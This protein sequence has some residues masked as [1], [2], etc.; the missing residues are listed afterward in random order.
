MPAL[1]V[2]ISTIAHGA[3][4]LAIAAAIALTALH[5]RTNS[6]SSAQDARVA[7]VDADSLTSKLAHCQAIGMAAQNDASCETVWAENRRRFFT[8]RPSDYP[9]VKPR[10]DQ[11]PAAKAEGR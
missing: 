9:P 4:C 10:I 2:K 3:G 8:F 11:P 5:L 7:P 1:F 6:Q